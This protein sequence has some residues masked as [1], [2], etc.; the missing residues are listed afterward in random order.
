M[1]EIMSDKLTYVAIIIS[2]LSLWI[3]VEATVRRVAY[4]VTIIPRRTIAVNKIFP[5]LLTKDFF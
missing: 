2:L 1:I 5:N 4:S 3:R